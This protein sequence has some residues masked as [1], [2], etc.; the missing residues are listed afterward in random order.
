MSPSP[1]IVFA[2]HSH[3]RIDERS[4]ASANRLEVAVGHQ[5]KRRQLVTR[6]RQE[7]IACFL[8]G[9]THLRD[10]DLGKLKRIEFE[11]A[12]TVLD[13]SMFVSTNTGQAH[14]G[15]EANA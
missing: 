12:A 4:T 10:F 9:A 1:S 6:L 5:E 15:M 8:N 11:D 2:R 14:A 7:A 3:H 13:S